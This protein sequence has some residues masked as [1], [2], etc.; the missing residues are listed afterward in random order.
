MWYQNVPYG[1]IKKMSTP[2]FMF[3]FIYKKVTSVGT[4]EV[5]S[6]NRIFKMAAFQQETADVLLLCKTRRVIL[7]HHIDLPYY[8]SLHLCNCIFLS[9]V[10]ALFLLFFC[11]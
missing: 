2:H 3:L 8:F 5:D 6:R 4:S 10:L 1:L 7:P 9:V 11:R